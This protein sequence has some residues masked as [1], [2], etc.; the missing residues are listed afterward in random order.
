MPRL[1]AAQLTYG[2]ITVVVAT[3]LLL[4]AS[5]A[6]SLLAVFG[7]TLVGLALG[8]AVAFGVRR[9]QTSAAQRAGR[10]V[11]STSYPVTVVPE[12]RTAGRVRES[13]LSHR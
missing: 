12:G 4:V 9:T 8:A 2:T 7:L 11:T 5:G 3:T 13:T 1:T 10:S 6:G